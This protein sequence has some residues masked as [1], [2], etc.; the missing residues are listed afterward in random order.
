MKHNIQNDISFTTLATDCFPEVLISACF[1]LL[2][3]KICKAFCDQKRE[4]KKS[5]NT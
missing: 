2:H 5:I 4:G 1:L 3:A